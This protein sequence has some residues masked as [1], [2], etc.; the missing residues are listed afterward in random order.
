MALSLSP[1]VISPDDTKDVPVIVVPVIAAAEDAP[2]IVPSMLPPL[3]SASE[4]VI[5]VGVKLTFT[6]VTVAPAPPP[7]NLTKTSAPFGT[8]KSLEA[9]Y[10]PWK[11]IRLREADKL[12][13]MCTIF[14]ASLGQAEHMPLRQDPLH[15]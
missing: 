13:R 1:K 2:I 8:S 7:S 10:V 14:S 4:V 15:H 5:L 6:S 12:L 3:M 9:L 11:R